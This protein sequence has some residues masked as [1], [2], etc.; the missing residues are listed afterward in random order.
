MPRR[1]A[2]TSWGS[3]LDLTLEVVRQVI[4][5]AMLLGTATR[6]DIDDARADLAEADIGARPL[7]WPPRAAQ[8]PRKLLARAWQTVTVQPGH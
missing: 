5:D 1:V 2:P 4:D 3:Q 7:P 8:D 6:R